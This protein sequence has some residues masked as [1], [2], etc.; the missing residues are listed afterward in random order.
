MRITS[1]ITFLFA[2]LPLLLFGQPPRKWSS[3]EIHQGIQ[4]L[5]FLG[6]ALYIAA[7][8]DDENTSL[9]SYLSNEVKANTA[10]LSL[11]RGDGGQNLIGP[12]IRELLGIIRTQELL[13]ARRID[14]GTQFFTRA[15]DFGYS[16]TAKE[17][18]TIWDKEEV[19]ADVIWA[20]RRWRPD[21]I[22]NRFDHTG[23]RPTHGHHTGSAMLSYE[24]FELS[25]KQDVHPEQQA[26]Y[27][28]WQARRAFHNISSWFYRNQP[29]GW[30]KV[31]KSE[32]VKLDIGKYYPFNGYSNGEISALSRSQHKSQG[33]GRI[34][35]RGTDLEYLELIQGDLPPDL[36]DPFSGINTTWSRVEGG[37]PIGEILR[38]VEEDF[39]FEQP[40]K[41]V[42]GLVEALDLMESLPDGYWKRVKME[43][44]KTLIAACLG[45]YMEALGEEAT[46][47]PGDSLEINLE[48]VSRAAGG[49]DFQGLRVSPQLWDSTLN[50]TLEENEKWTKQ[51]QVRL[52]E[53]FPY[54]NAYWLN[55]P[56]ELGMYQV[57]DQQLIGLPETPR[58]LRV[59][60]DFQVY[61]KTIRWE[62]DVVFRRSDPVEG[63]VY[64]PFEILPVV[65]I[66]LDQKVQVF[67]Q[68]EPQ[69][70]EL[71]V[72]ANRENT[73]GVVRMDV[74]PGWQLKPR[75]ASFSIPLKGGEERIR[76]QLTPPAEQSEGR[77]RPYAIVEG[78]TF[79]LEKVEIDYDHIPSQLVL[80]ESIAKVVR[81]ELKKAGKRIGY[82]MG[83]GDEVPFSLEQMG[84]EVVLLE[85]ED[86]KADNLARFD[87]VVTGVR[88]YNTRERMRFLQ[89][90]LLAYVEQGGTLVIQYNTS[91]RLKLP[92]EE[93]APD[94]L[95]LSRD[96]VTV[97]GAEVRFLKPGHEVLNHPNRITD[98]DFEG[99]VQERGLYYPDHW[100]PSFEAI[101]SMNDP[102]EEPMNGSLLVA[103]H[104]KG[105]YV[106][107]GLSFFRELPA[108][109]P[110]AYRLF[111]NLVSLG[112][113][114][115]P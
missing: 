50:L 86:V 75:E 31:D 111:A 82:L 46:A 16:K 114:D 13:A 40:E 113:K 53:D 55:E 41:S 74:P 14:G 17:S 43:E 2:L 79:R 32:M 5:N 109:V 8:P 81:V 6:S 88:A 101:L 56:W 59:A 30:E 54:S 47:S 73:E 64:R 69:T 29:G 27:P 11:T 26:F 95:E 51:I 77:I 103:R 91:F 97:E 115:K 105:H 84:Y 24:A 110:G 106:Y 20:I 34:G 94:T 83:A 61:G 99:W 1:H 39:D 89:P 108:G 60:F 36:S 80:R 76:F 96:R 9:I 104:G 63:E 58:R 49:L 65:G 12:E 57:E 4:K 112:Q 92:M 19:L 70:V 100:G 28:P 48:V 7:H 35:V 87:A 93:M 72:R 66:S 10:Y 21:I 71:I 102:G 68:P 98:A 22:I 67:T 62:K 90:E 33:F 52:P 42:P 18:F 45:L 25:G 107:T 44:A 37:E 15:N 3:S 85:D 78:D 23:K 38:R